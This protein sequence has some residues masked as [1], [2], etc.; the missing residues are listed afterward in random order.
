[1]RTQNQRPPGPRAIDIASPRARHVKIVPLPAPTN[2]NPLGIPNEPR[3]LLKT[4]EPPK[5]EIGGGHRQGAFTASRGALCAPFGTEPRRPAKGNEDARSVYYTPPN[6]SQLATISWA[7]AVTRP[8]STPPACHACV[9]AGMSA[10]AAPD[11]R[12]PLGKAAWRAGLVAA[13]LLCGAAIPGC[14]SAF[15]PIHRPQAGVAA[16]S[17]ELCKTRAE[18]VRILD[19]ALHQL[20]AARRNRPSKSG[21]T[22]SAPVTQ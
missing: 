13:M 6:S 21:P 2:P 8:W 10:Q 1:M 20:N 3:K 12:M 4:K 19:A 17:M 16:S 14:V 15:R 7:C 5:K 22:L 9:H 11:P 18:P